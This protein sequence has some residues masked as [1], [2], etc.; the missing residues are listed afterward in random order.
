VSSECGGVYE[1][2]VVIGDFVGEKNP[3]NTRHRIHIQFFFGGHPYSIQKNE[4][5]ASLFT[6][7][8]GPNSGLPRLF[9][10][11]PSVVY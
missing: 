4:N 8:N 6:C 7:L 3:D 2:R 5:R 1:L 9:I 11:G 10:N